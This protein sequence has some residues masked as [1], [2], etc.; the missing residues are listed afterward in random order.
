M[1][2]AAI[3]GRA[4]PIVLPPLFGSYRLLIAESGAEVE[5]HLAYGRFGP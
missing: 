1:P 2:I 5:R 4:L 3:E